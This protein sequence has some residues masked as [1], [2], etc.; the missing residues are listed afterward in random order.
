MD[1]VSES[2]EGMARCGIS[3]GRVCKEPENG[4]VYIPMLSPKSVL[5]RTRT[6]KSCCTFPMISTA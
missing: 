5:V 6:L 4:S 1:C 3:G 2:K